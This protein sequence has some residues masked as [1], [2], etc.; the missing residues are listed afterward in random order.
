MES[1]HPSV[2]LPR[3][4]GFEDRPAAR[5]KRS[6]RPHEHPRRP[7]AERALKSA[8]LQIGRKIINPC[9]PGQSCKGTP[10]DP[11]G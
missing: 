4:A 11:E 3:P 1:N 9:T 5:D 2:G 10:T 7:P 8:F 6:V